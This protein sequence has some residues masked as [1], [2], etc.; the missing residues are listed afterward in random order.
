MLHLQLSHFKCAISPLLTDMADAVVIGRG[1]EAESAALQAALSGLSDESFS[2]LRV[3]YEV[4]DRPR[5]PHVVV[6]DLI[7]VV[8]NTTRTNASHAWTRMQSEPDFNVNVIHIISFRFPGQRGRPSE[9]VN[10]PAAL[11]IIML[12]PGRTAAKVRVKAAVLLTRFLA[13]DLT[14]VGEVYG[15]AA[16]QDYLQEHNPTHPLCT[17]RQAVTAGQTTSSSIDAAF[18]TALNTLAQITTRLE[19][20]PHVAQTHGVLEISRS[21]VSSS[22]Q[23]ELLSIGTKVDDTQLA[24]INA[25]GGPLHLS[26]FL[27]EQGVRDD[28]IRRLTPTFAAEVARRKLVQY[29][30]TDRSSP[31]WIVWSLAAWRLY[32]TEADRELIVSVFEDPL[33]KQSIERLENS[34]QR[35][36][37]AAPITARRRQGPYRCPLQGSSSE[38]TP[39]T[40]REYFSVPEMIEM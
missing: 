16:L 19:N 22:R 8:T 32:Y 38:A 34:N 40:I 13:G 2:R 36:R 21:R 6:T 9:V 37:A 17:F 5:G 15:M 31:L 11:Q 35:K 29:D 20:Q 7:E 3:C 27:Q 30:N 14:L 28:L 4:P 23:D 26:C 1:S 18:T 10:I 25:E 24:V 39:R 33:T 12:L